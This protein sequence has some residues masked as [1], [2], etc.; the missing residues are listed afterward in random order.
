MIFDQMPRICNPWQGAQ[1]YESK[2]ENAVKYGKT[3]C[4]LYKLKAI[5][6][7]SDVISSF[8]ARLIVMGFISSF[9]LFLSLGFALWLGEILGNTYVGFFL[10]AVF[11]G[12]MGIFIRLFLSK[13][14]K[15]TIS[16]QVINQLLK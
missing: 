12:I 7:T 8:I 5:D 10:V 14:L 16:N 13:Q 2:L 9:L 1:G 11:Y 6:K 4:K 15:M 3:S